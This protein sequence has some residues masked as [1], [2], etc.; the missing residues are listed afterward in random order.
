MKVIYH[1]LLYKS[2]THVDCFNYDKL[3]FAHD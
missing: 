1:Y 3:V 2:E